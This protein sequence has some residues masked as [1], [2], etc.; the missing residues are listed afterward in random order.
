[1]FIPFDGN[2]LIDRSNR[3][4][5][6]VRSFGF[7]LAATYD[8]ND[9]SS[10]DANVQYQDYFRSV[11][12]LNNNDFFASVDYGHYVLK[13]DV[14]LVASFVYQ[15]SSADFG[16]QTLLTFLPGIALESN[17]NFIILLN[18]QF[19][20]T[21]TNVQNTTGFNVAWTMTF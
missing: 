8:F 12:G 16:N 20:L 6:Q 2:T 19:S 17:P 3:N 1:M 18:G 9:K 11:P 21:G 4:S 13:N 15:N 14:L 10:V 7:G 5:S